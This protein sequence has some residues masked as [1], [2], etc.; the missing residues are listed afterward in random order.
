MAAAHE[1]LSLSFFDHIISLSGHTKSIPVVRGKRGV[2][3]IGA[4][5]CMRIDSLG[6]Y[7][8]Y[9]DGQILP[10]LL[11]DSEE[12]PKFLSLH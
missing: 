12:V 4:F 7:H 9:K 6:F 2:K 10:G 5:G 8:I 11:L 1:I 3:K